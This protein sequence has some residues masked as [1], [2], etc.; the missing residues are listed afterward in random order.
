MYLFIYLFISGS[1]AKV[2]FKTDNEVWNPTLG[3]KELLRQEPLPSRDNTQRSCVHEHTAQPR[4]FLTLLKE[5]SYLSGFHSQKELRCQ[6]LIYNHFI[7]DTA[8]QDQS[9]TQAWWQKA[10][11]YGRFVFPFVKMCYKDTKMSPTSAWALRGHCL[12]SVCQPTQPAMLSVQVLQLLGRWTRSRAL[13]CMLCDD[14]SLH[15]YLEDVLHCHCKMW[16]STLK[17]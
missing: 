15:G 3:Y 16:V 8:D 11:L 12:N 1:S 17:E 14:W 4:L 5:Q 10:K 2:N 13:N 6:N 7:F 9:P